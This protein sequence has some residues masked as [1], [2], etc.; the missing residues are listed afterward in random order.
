LLAAAFIGKGK[1]LIVP[2]LVKH[3]AGGVLFPFWAMAGLGRVGR[4][5]RIESSNSLSVRARHRR[6]RDHERRERNARH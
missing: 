1:S 6:R 3:R 2:N 5:N 4:D